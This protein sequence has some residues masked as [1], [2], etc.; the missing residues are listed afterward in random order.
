[1]FYRRPG[2]WLALLA[3]AAGAQATGAPWTVK[4]VH[5]Y[6]IALAVETIPD[7]QPSGT[8]SRHAQLREHRLLVSIQGQ[9]GRRVPPIAVWANVAEAGYA[10]TAMPLAPVGSGKDLVFEGRARLSTRTAHRILIY[11]TPEAGSRTLE[12][13]FE[14]RHHH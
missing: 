7:A 5:G 10:G 14:Y 11:A 3:V 1:M 13:H 12:A 9:N 4:S 6:R 8:D 2:A